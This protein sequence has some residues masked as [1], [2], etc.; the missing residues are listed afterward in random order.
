MVKKNLDQCTEPR[1]SRRG[2]LG[3]LVGGTT[4]LAL[5]AC[6]A[7]ISAAPSGNETASK[8]PTTPNMTPS[9]PELKP[10]HITPEAQAQY[11]AMSPNEKAVF[12]AKYFAAVFGG[13]AGGVSGEIDKLDP[14][15]RTTLLAAA[16]DSAIPV[17]L[18]TYNTSGSADMTVAKA[19]NDYRINA[20]PQAL[21]DAVDI[22][23]ATPAQMEQD[24][25]SKELGAALVD[26]L[27]SPESQLSPDLKT[28]ADNGVGVIIHAPVTAA[29]RVLRS[30]TIVKIN[31]QQLTLADAGRVYGS[32]QGGKSFLTVVEAHPF[33]DL[34]SG[35]PNATIFTRYS[36]EV[37]NDTMHSVIN[38]LSS[39][40][41]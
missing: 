34:R 37:P 41:N 26:D 10:G 6:G 13:E 32:E 11:R 27:V 22:R 19:L 5:E 40:T 7:N 33:N 21:A 25:A 17:V 8:N 20:E 1:I 39:S 18:D 23:Y 38:S 15:A 2:L 14:D 12:S 31:K 35:E 30:G 28:N 24:A 4:L 29:T 9:A 3:A 16:I 36:E